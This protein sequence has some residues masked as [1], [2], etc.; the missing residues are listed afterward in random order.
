MKQQT[1]KCPKCGKEITQWDESGP[2]E[3]D[4]YYKYTCECGFKG[5]EWHTL[6]FFQHT[7]KNGNVVK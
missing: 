6:Q 5:T 1:N 7:D 2:V 4:Y 3:E